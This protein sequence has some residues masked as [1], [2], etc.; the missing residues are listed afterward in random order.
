MNIA[1]I[2]MSKS[3]GWKKLEELVQMYEPNFTFEPNEVYKI[4]LLTGAVILCES[5][6]IPNN[7][8]FLFDQT[9]ATMI[10]KKGLADLYIIPS[11][12][13]KASINIG[14]SK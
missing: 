5:M 12:F 8:G 3:K 1:T 6:D 13:E 7:E 14:D 9:N 2:R 11:K 4:Q 10:Y